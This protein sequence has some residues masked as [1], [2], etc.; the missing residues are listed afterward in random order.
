MH[1][2]LS[3]RKGKDDA[4]RRITTTLGCPEWRNATPSQA[5]PYLASYFVW[6]RFLGTIPG[7]SYL[8]GQLP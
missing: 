7:Q 5:E 3:A 6:A 1:L 8:A 4:F 2:Y